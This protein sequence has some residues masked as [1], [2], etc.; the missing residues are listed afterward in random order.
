MRKA[1]RFLSKQGHF[2]PCQ[3]T[4]QETVKLV[5]SVHFDWSLTNQE[6]PATWRNLFQIH[7]L[8]CR[9]ITLICFQETPFS[10]ETTFYVKKLTPG[11]KEQ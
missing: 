7:A 1:G 6:Q 4:K 10:V 11:V 5:N 9:I 2:Q 8:L 3:A